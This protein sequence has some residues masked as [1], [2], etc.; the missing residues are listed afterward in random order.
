MNEWI[1][2]EHGRSLLLG[3]L[4]VAVFLA[5]RLPGLGR[6]VTADEGLWLRQS[7]RFLSAVT[8][9][10]WEA[11]EVSQHPGVTTTWAGALG[12]LAT[13]TAYADVDDAKMSDAQW[14]QF[15]RVQGYNPA[16]ILAAGR[17][18]VVLFCAM[19]FGASWP[20]AERLLGRWPAAI[21]MGLLALDPF[22]IAHQRLLHQDGLMSAFMLLS[23]LAMVDGVLRQS[24][25]ALLVSGIAAGLSWLTKSPAWLLAPL[26]AGLLAWTTWR[27]ARELKRAT[28]DGLF[29]LGAGLLV[30]VALYPAAWVA[31]GAIFGGVIE[32]TLSSAEGGFSGPVF[33]NGLVYADGE[34]GLASGWFYTLNWLWRSTPLTVLGL[35]AAIGFVRQAKEER[36]PLGTLVVFAVGFGLLMTLGVKKFDRYLLP[37]MFALLFVAG[38]GWAQAANWVGKRGAG[39]WLVGGLA[40]AVLALQAASSLAHFPYYLTYYNAA[41]GGIDQAQ[42]VMLVGWGEGLDQAAAYLN[43]H[44]AENVASWYSTSFNLLYEGYA[45]HIPITADLT[46]DQMDRILEADYLVIYVHQYQRQTPA[47]LLALLEEIEPVNVVQLA[48]IDYVWVYKLGD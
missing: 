36:L 44:N 47:D 10:D 1:R 12:Y 23:V 43:E 7:G 21:G 11:T 33:F 16:Q 40:A 31:P 5:V 19:A 32:Y 14:R 25:G 27:G 38:W 35:L 39:R 6:F 17:A 48:G 41:L 45:D 13:F 42:D 37:A 26:A 3:A 15:L 30:F 29:W 9:G 46:A 18:M 24:R 8:H 4:L 34:M 22:S 28:L 20:F 2:G